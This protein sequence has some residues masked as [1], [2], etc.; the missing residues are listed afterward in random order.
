MHYFIGDWRLMVWG[1][2]DTMRAPDGV[3]EWRLD[4]GLDGAL[5]LTGQVLLPEENRIMT[6]ELISYDP[7]GRRFRRSIV[8]DDSTIYLF[9]SSGW[10]GDSLEWNGTAVRSTGRVLMREVVHRKGP[11]LFEAVFL[12]RE[13]LSW[14]PVSWER[15]SRIK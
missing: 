12:V 8:S 6:R 5:A 13:G 4:N 14:V 2:P 3:G 10:T 1:D 11:D 9:D 15:L 7:D